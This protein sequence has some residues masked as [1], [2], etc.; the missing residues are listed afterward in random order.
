MNDDPRDRDPDDAAAPEDAPV[1][2]GEAER[3]IT[4]LLRST[5]L[6][7]EDSA[8]QAEVLEAIDG[9]PPTSAPSRGWRGVV[10]P[11]VTAAVAA[12]A[13]LVLWN[14][15]QGTPTPEGEGGAGG[16]PTPGVTVRALDH[17]TVRGDERFHAG[18][19]IELRAVTGDA[20]F[21]EL[22]VYHDDRALLVRCPGDSACTATEGVITTSLRLPARGQVQPLLL[23]AKEPLP[24]P[25]GS[26]DEDVA[27]AVGARV[28]VPEPI[29]IR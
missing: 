4:A 17:A 2:P 29:E 1:E 7:G 6:E 14:P 3:A 11:L 8:W 20:A 28:I 24:E 23:L 27:A 10:T 13:V 25:T 19:E 16:S 12:A 26:L 5:G 21:A 9:A 15:D 22:R 18:A